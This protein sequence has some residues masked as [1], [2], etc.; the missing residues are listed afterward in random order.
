[1]T[2]GR[3][4]VRRGGIEDVDAVLAL[5]R[6]VAEAPHWSRESYAAIVGKS[7]LAGD[8]C[9]GYPGAAGGE[10][11][12]AGRVRRTLF[13]VEESGDL[14]GFS[15]GSLWG[16]ELIV[17]AVGNERNPL[18]GELETVVV[19]QAERRRG[20]GRALCLAVVEWCRVEGAERVDLEVRAGSGGAVA[21]YEDLGFCVTARRRGYYSDPVEDALLMALRVTG[22]EVDGGPP[23]LDAR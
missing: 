6:Q 1:M 17:T 13:V 8:V 7:V 11:G 5:E 18:W 21:L 22:A 16:G 19:A 12:G 2:A 9:A 14:L 3:W 15:V 4:R 10:Q 20:A 23:G